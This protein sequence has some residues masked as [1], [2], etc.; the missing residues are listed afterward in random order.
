[1]KKSELRQLIKEEINQVKVD[2]SYNK[3]INLI[4]VEARKLSYDDVYELHEKLK[5]FLN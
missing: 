1:M 4:R 3:I 2:N 5:K